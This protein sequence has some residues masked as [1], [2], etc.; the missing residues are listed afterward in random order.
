MVRNLFVCF[1]FFSVNA[2]SQNRFLNL[3]VGE[4]HY[5]GDLGNDKIPR[6]LYPAYG[7]GFTV[8]LTNNML[9]NANLYN[10]KI[11]GHDKFNA[12]TKSRNLS[13]Y[14]H[15]TEF[16]VQFQYNLF[17]L[18]EY[19]VTPHFFTGIAVFNF[20]PYTKTQS[21]NIVYL[22]KLKTEG[23]G[24]Y[25][26]RKPYKTTQFSIPIGAGITWA[27]TDNKRLSIFGGVRKTFTDYL[28]DVSTTYIDENLLQFHTGTDAVVLAFREDELNTSATYPL[29]GAQRGN[30]KNKDLYFFTGLSFQFRI[31]PHRRKEHRIKKG[32][33]G[34][35]ACPTVY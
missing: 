10:G 32:R 19:S 33:R 23:Q 3:Y 12:K 4:S 35:T 31:Q 22:Q 2:F 34:S 28:D 26:N 14:S 17:D 7:L 24:F 20:S 16:S 1:F 6:L 29:E 15:L 27:L 25:Q 9:I 5:S 30:A 21:G 18:Y 11:G 13:F 8:E